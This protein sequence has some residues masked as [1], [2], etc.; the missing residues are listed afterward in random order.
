MRD[1]Q[2]I[3]YAA[4]DT[5]RNVQHGLDRLRLVMLATVE[6]QVA[7]RSATMA[8]QKASPLE[9]PRAA[10]VLRLHHRGRYHRLAGAVSGICL[11][12]R[13]PSPPKS[14]TNPELGQPIV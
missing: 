1:T 4:G 12:F 10:A 9:L 14:Q 2:V 3:E 11:Q 8:G 13:V 5:W 7:Q 6:G